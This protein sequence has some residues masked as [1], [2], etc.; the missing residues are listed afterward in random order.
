HIQD[1][2]PPQPYGLSLHDALPISGRTEHEVHL[3]LRR[4]QLVNERNQLGIVGYAEGERFEA[5]GHACCLDLRERLV[6]LSR[7]CAGIDDRDRKSTRLNSS[8]VKIS[9]AVFCL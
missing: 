3:P 1:I 7:A 6:A 4:R 8:H 2:P 5:R 9:Y